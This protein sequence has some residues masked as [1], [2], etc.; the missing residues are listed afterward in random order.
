[1]KYDIMCTA[2]SQNARIAEFISFCIESFAKFKGCSGAEI[3]ALF[4]RCGALE[5]LRRG[6]DVLHTMGEGWL[7][8]DM[9]EYL[10]MRGLAA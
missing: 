9:S 4:G 3:A 6:Y 2:M 5:Y 1:M 8:E 7:V 10:R